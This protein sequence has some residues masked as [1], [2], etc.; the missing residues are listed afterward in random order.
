MTFLFRRRNSESLKALLSK[1][2]PLS[3][4]PT[5]FTKKETNRDTSGDRCKLTG[6]TRGDFSA[7]IRACQMMYCTLEYRPALQRLS[8]IANVVASGPKGIGRTR[9]SRWNC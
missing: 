7:Q 4:K 8:E 6:G 3:T 2:A 5:A 9:K 1:K